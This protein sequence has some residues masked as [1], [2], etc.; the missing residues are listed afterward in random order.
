FRW[1]RKTGKSFFT[2]GKIKFWVIKR[3]V[4][5][6]SRREPKETALPSQVI[7]ERE[8]SVKPRFEEI[9]RW[10]ASIESRSRTSIAGIVHRVSH[11]PF[12]RFKKLV[13]KVSHPKIPRIP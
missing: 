9:L 1:T 8:G 10:I 7:P 12:H 5:L 13:P 6:Y 11:I 3:R 2:A 4:E